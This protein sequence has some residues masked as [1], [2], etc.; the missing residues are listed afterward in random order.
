[1]DCQYFEDIFLLSPIAAYKSADSSFLSKWYLLTFSYCIWYS[2]IS[3]L[4]TGLSFKNLFC[5]SLSIFFWF[6][7][8]WFLQVWKILTI[9][10]LDIA[11]PS[12]SIFSPPE[13]LLD[14]YWLFHIYP[15]GLWTHLGCSGSL[16]YA[17]SMYFSLYIKIIYIRV[18]WFKISYH[19]NCSSGF[20]SSHASRPWH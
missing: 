8:P 18:I 10:S 7:N 3:L 16:L 4:Y 9:I 5:L 15:S 1:M 19:I 20:Q 17:F 11:S 13:T 12:Y 14:V 2:V 6:G